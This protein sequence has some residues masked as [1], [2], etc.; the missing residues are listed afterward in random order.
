MVEFNRRSK[1]PTGAAPRPGVTAD[2]YNKEAQAYSEAAGSCFML[3]PE[4]RDEIRVWNRYYRIKGMNRQRNDMVKW[5][6]G[7]GPDTA[8]PETGRYRWA[9]PSQWP[10]QFD[11]SVSEAMC[12]GTGRPE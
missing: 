6:E 1:G 9:V 5:L 2:N 7:R 10:W 11:Q 4:K 12:R 3:V 8:H